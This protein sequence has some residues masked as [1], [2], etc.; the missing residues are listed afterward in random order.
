VR[1]NPSSPNVSLAVW[2]PELNQTYQLILKGVLDI[3]KGI[4]PDFDIFDVDLFYTPKETIQALHDK[5]KRVICYFSA[6]SAEDWRP[7]WSQFQDIDKGS[8]LGGWSGERWLDIRKDGVWTVMKS[9]IKLAS[10]KGCDAIDPDNMGRS[11]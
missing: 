8:C 2:Q 10:E 3:S 6:G 1:A 7:D 9:R 5:G 4:V 11:H